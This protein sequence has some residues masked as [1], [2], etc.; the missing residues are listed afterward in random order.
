MSRSVRINYEL[1]AKRKREIYL[2]HLKDRIRNNLSRCEQH[3]HQII[4]SGLSE[5]VKEEYDTLVLNVANIRESYST[6]PERF[7]ESSSNIVSSAMTLHTKAINVRKM[8]DQKQAEYTEFLYALFKK[9]PNPVVRDFAYDECKQLVST[10]K[11]IK[12]TLENKDTISSRVLGQ[13]DTIMQRAELKAKKWMEE[14]QS[15]AELS[16]IATMAE[17]QI[18][19]VEDSTLNTDIHGADKIS[20]LKNIIKQTHPD[21]NQDKDQLLNELHGIM[22]TQEQEVLDETYRRE[23]I[24]AIAGTLNNLGFI[25][26]KPRLIN[27]GEKDIVLIKAQRPAGQECTFKVTKDGSMEYSF[28]KYE[29]ATCKKDI[30]SFLPKLEQVYGIKLSNERVIWENPDKISKDARQS[31]TGGSYKGGQK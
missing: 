16:T 27:E 11:D 23:S 18:A 24:T 9:F 22:A 7:T 20:K 29:G 4:Q 21:G 13:F 2:N 5:L 15:E 8:L 28:E 31:P 12:L 3:L 19:V 14:K 6:D 1:E 25:V 10:W 30:D 26:S 17:Q